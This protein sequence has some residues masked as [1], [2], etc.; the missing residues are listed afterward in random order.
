MVATHLSVTD[1]AGFIIKK[2]IIRL[3]K[4]ASEGFGLGNEFLS[5]I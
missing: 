2:Y 5:H 3:V 4:G 1:I